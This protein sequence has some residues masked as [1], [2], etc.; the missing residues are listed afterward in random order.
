M[1]SCNGTTN[2]VVARV[3]NMV[4]T[5]TTLD[6][7][8]AILA[9]GRL[10][11]NPTGEQFR[12]IRRQAL[13]SL[14][15]SDWVIGEAMSRGI[16]V[17]DRE[18]QQAIAKRERAYPGGAPEFRAFLKATNQ[19]MPDVRL[20]ARTELASLK[21]RQNVIGTVAKV[22]STQIARYYRDHQQ[23]FTIPEER[24]VAISNRKSRAAADKLR[25]QVEAGGSLLSRHQ[26][27]VGEVSLTVRSALHRRN[28]LETAIYQAR[29]HE[30]TGPVL[31]GGYTY[32]LFRVTKVVPARRRPRS[33]VYDL[34]RKRLATDAVRRKLSTSVET[35]RARWI[36][37]TDCR[38]QY[39][40]Q[41]CRQYR[42]FK[43][44]EDSQDF[45]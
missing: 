23:S 12:A 1:A 27:E 35:W 11:A 21:L 24:R 14:I 16:D 38:P 25:R 9:G 4:I 29:P 31:V 20:E 34:I 13:E 3:G 8:L 26:R 18:V 33:E 15:S 6:H 17:S 42:G 40:M 39:V 19:T 43:N 30:L 22:T 28:E 45:S 41:K 5:R 7:R 37:A 10:P 32:Y 36:A 44:P 2:G